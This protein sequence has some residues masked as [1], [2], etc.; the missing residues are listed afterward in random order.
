MASRVELDPSSRRATGVTYVREGEQVERMQR[1][2]VVAVAGYS[3][4]TPR[5]LLNSSTK[6]FPNGLC[7]NEDQ[8][9]RY[10]MVQGATQAAGR[11]PTCLL[12]TSRCV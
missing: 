4:E 1:A 7:N 6:G 12:Y 9:G 10:V 3:I 5:L 11:F 2:K 8:V